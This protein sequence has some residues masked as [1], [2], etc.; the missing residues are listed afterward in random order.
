M[1][2]VKA[3]LLVGLLVLGGCGREAG[4]TSDG[5]TSAG[6]PTDLVVI[7][8]TVVDDAGRPV[9]G[10]LVQPRSLDE[11][12]LAVPELAVMSGPDGRY[13][14]RLAAG[15]YEFTALKG[16][17]TGVPAEVVAAPGTVDAA[18]EVPLRL[19]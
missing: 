2:H 18:R 3:V 5:G 17:R 7:A 4:T 11:P 1:G 13:E 6:N 15:R 8:G 9:E 19:P 14:W 12:P 16:E 10:A